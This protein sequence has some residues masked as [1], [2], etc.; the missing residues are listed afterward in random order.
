M[1]II[2]IVVRWVVLYT[3]NQ[4]LNLLMSFSS[5]TGISHKLLHYTNVLGFHIQTCVESIMNEPEADDLQNGG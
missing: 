4:Q 5:K 2:V 3:A 1:M